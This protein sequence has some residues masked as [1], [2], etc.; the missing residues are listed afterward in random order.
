MRRRNQI[1]DS[2]SD[3]E[4]GEVTPASASASASVAASVASGSGSVGGPSPPNPGPVQVPF[5]SLSPSPDTV[6]ISDD[7]EVEDPDEIVDSDGDS[8]I[9]DAPEVI[10]PPTPPAPAPT[11]PPTTAPFRTPAPAPP[12]A[13]TSTPTP[14]LPAPAP[15]PPP[16][17]T[18][19]RTATPTPPPARTP[20]PTPLSTAH[21]QPSA[22]S[23]RLRPVDEFLRRLGLRLRPEWLES[24]AAG[25]P[26]F[27]GLG[28]AEVQA[29][30]CFEQFVFADMNR[31]GA[32]V[33]PEGVGSMHAA[34]LDGPFVLPV[35]EIVNVSVPL[36]GRYHDAHAG[37]KRCLK[38]SMTDG[39]QHI[40]GMEYRPVKDLAVLA[41]A[42]LK[43]VIKNVHIR[44]GVLMI[45]PEVIEIL[46]GVVDE[47]EAARD[48]LV[49][50]VNKPPR[51]KRKQ[52]GLPLSSRTTLAAW[53]CSTNVTNGGEQGISMPR[54]ANFSHLTG[55]GTTRLST[56]IMTS[57]GEQGIAMPRAVN[58]TH[59]TGLG[60]AFRVGRTTETVV[61]DHVSPPVVVN[62]A[63]GQIQDVQEINMEDLSTYHTRED[64]CTSSH[65]VNEYD[66]TH[67]I[68]RSTQTIIEE[69][70]GP[71][72]RSSNA[73]EQIQH[74][75]E[76]TLQE[77]A[78]A[79]GTIER[80][81]SV[82]SPFGYVSQHVSHIIADTAA[83]DVEAAQS[84]NVDVINQKE[85]SFILSG[86]NEKP[87]TYIC[88]MLAD[89]G[90]QAVTKASIQGKIKGVFTS[91]KC[92]QFRQRTKY[93]L[94]VYIDDGSSISEAIVH[95][96][97]VKKVLGLSPGELTAALAG[98][99]EFTSTSEVIETVKGFQRFLAKFEGMMLIECNKDSSIPIIRDLDD[100]CSSSNAWLL[101]RRLKTFSSRRC[102]WNHD[103]M[104]TT[105]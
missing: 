83:N 80:I 63:Q 59:P 57:R 101:L 7:D 61:E 11:P 9:V 91:V 14:P 36:K 73:H 82:S 21:P 45:V 23:G 49:S 30:R 60:N 42:G 96:D 6:V 64:T 70:V 43:V 58:S 3:E 1:V 48:R 52:G 75:Q 50:E 12:P 56:T 26:G 24:C 98:V 31:C 85:H 92:F 74:A 97:I 105:P 38:L 66:R 71:P 44:R 69:C 87:F 28:G 18:P 27:D 51:G 10:S 72:I 8:P 95:H 29:R 4:G 90:R 34:V 32:G 94:Y 2:D 46:G 65:T 37:P 93:E 103:C 99:F 40:Y 88:S 68:E 79:F 81:S 76:I 53:P 67:I 13:R 55:L 62:T 17:T 25:I 84:P 15:A 5:P 20:T 78:T 22:L 102:M 86:K 39:I 104:D 47:L 35:D 77:Q 16:T 54:A 100:G 89:W 19:F 41:P 33:L